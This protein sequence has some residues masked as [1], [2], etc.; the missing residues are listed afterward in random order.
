MVMI[1]ILK[2]LQFLCRVYVVSIGRHTC[3]C[4][5]LQEE[6]IENDHKNSVDSATWNIDRNTK[7][8]KTD[9][10]GKIQFS[11][12]GQRIG[13]A[14]TVGSTGAGFIMTGKYHQCNRG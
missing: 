13:Q 3:A 4:G 7:L 9:A 8:V 14:S 1:A 11:G 10:Y 2:Q 6:H 5:Y 12:V